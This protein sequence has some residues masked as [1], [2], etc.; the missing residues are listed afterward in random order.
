MITILGTGRAL[1]ERRVD[2]SEFDAR[3]SLPTGQLAAATGVRS[4]Y[5]C[6]GESQVDLALAAATAA[7][8]DAGL[9][10]ADID[11]VICGAAVPYQPIPATAPLLMQRLGMTDGSASAFDVNATCLGFVVALD[12]AARLIA[13]GGARRALVVSAEIASRALPWETQ[14]EVAALFGDGAGAAVVEAGA[15]LKAS[16]TRTYPSAYDACSIGAGGTRFD[17][18]A[19]PEDFAAHAWFSMDGKELFRLASR[20]FGAFVTDLLAR[21]GWSQDDVDLIVPHQASPAALV[22]MVRQTGFDAGKVV[23][24]VAD[25]GNQIAASIPFTLDTARRA[26]RVPPGTRVLMLGTSAGV[27]FG[28][29]AY[30]A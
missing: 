25:H 11:L 13:T 24:I 9:A 29:L 18:H 22:H 26:G 28:G 15:G 1:P 5:V 8:A 19:S 6:D 4:R 7:L 27:S 10:P 12:T 2:S 14:P 23:D 30:E 3:L 20:H 21:A 17:F 16:L